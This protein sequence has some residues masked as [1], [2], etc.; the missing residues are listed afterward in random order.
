MPELF[1][2]KQIELSKEGMQ[3]LL[4]Q[5]QTQLS[6]WF[7]MAKEYFLNLTLLQLVAW[8]CIV[9]GVILVIIALI[10]W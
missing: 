3:Q 1:M 6:N 4:E 10:I 8:G 2:S 7:N 5:I 9:V